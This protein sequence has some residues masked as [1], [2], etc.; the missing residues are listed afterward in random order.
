MMRSEDD[1]AF[2][3]TLVELAKRLKLTTVAEWVQDEAA[4]KTLQDWGCDYLQGA[5]VG[6]ATTE[7]P[8][9]A[10]LAKAV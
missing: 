4:A 2:V 5:L 3:R 1:R 8:W 6:L 7:R 10:G 9:H